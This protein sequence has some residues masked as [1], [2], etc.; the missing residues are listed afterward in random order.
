M[1]GNAKQCRQHLRHLL[2]SID[3]VFRPLDNL[4]TPHRKH[5]PSLKKMKAGDANCDTRKVILGW[6][7]DTIKGI[8][9]LPE[10]RCEQLLKIF[11]CL[12][13]QQRV[14]LGKWHKMLGKLQ[15]TSLGTL[16]SKGLFSLLQTRI[17]CSKVNQI[18]LTT[19]MKAHLQD[20]EHLAHDLR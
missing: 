5:V 11:E 2:H 15:S 18:C 1:Q 12:R 6:I 20:F 7:V 19:A 3:K 4:D 10:H 14:T 8:I 9:T 16:G 13:H 17:T